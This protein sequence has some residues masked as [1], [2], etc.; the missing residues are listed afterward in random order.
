MV[1]IFLSVQRE[2]AQTV[3]KRVV[4][5]KHMASHPNMSY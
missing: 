5:R 4:L 1:I 2:I 3:P